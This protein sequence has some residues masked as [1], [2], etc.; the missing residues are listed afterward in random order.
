[1]EKSLTLLMILFVLWG[2][3]DKR[4]TDNETYIP[5]KTAEVTHVNDNLTVSAGGAVTSQDAPAKLSFL[6]SGRVMRIVPGEGEFVRRGELI[7]ELDPTDYRLAVQRAEAQAEMAKAAYEKADSPVRP[8][9]LEQARIACERAKDEHARMKTLYDS[10]SLAPNDY[11]KFRAA[12]E[13]AE[14][15]YEMAKNGGQKEDKQQAKAALRQAEAALSSV[16]KS[17]GD[18][19]LYAVSDGYMS[20]RFVSEGET[21]S[22]GSPVAEIV[23][24]DP[25]DV[26][27]GVPEKDIR[28]LEAGQVAEV[29]L[30]A[31]PEQVFEG[32]VRL[33][34]VSADP[35]TRT[36]LVK[37]EVQNP[38]KLLKIGM[39]ADVSV[40]TSERADMLTV[41]LNTIVRDAQ[42]APAVFVV[43]E[44]RAYAVKVETGRLYKTSIE[45]KNGLK[46][47][48]TIVSAG[49][50][51]LRD[52]NGVKP[53][54]E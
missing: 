43:K 6:V 47:D 32:I 15:Q 22:A 51:R 53:A 40:K 3:G 54:A 9:Q 11:L 39:A 45:I 52:G 41:P 18:T 29:R 7:A 33:V 44:N 1:M 14:R 42:G 49:Q 12:Y 48:E 24:L 35:A 34:N 20:K 37:I 21:V 27:A 30:A 23:K 16:R 46:G 8:E 38:R 31:L 19:K 28:L 26:S 13:S 17:L 5:V 10:G 36:Y 50:E 25:V 4:E 2:C